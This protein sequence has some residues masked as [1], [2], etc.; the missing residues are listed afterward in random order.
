MGHYANEKKPP[1]S[2]FRSE[3]IRLLHVTGRR[4]DDFADHVLFALA[5]GT[6]LRV[7]EISAL[8]VVDVYNEN[9]GARQRLELTVFKH[10]RGDDE[11]T[12]QEVMIGD[13]LRK[14]LSAFYKWKKTR[15]HE[16][17]DCAPLFVVRG[18]RRM[19][20]RRMR[21]RFEQWRKKYLFH[22][23]LSFHSLRHTHLQ[24]L[25]ESTGNILLVSKQARHKKVSTT[26]IYAQPSSEEVLKAINA[27]E[28]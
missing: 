11:E 17:N 5:L 15:R 14:K 25:Y 1:K 20:A 18:G 26:M 23:W 19:S 13:A 4:C 6:A 21:E 22:D 27:M 7:H 12:T 9:H 28:A 3:E 8:D 2:M 24:R 16:L 10:R